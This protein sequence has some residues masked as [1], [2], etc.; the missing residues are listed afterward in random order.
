MSS[1]A[2]RVRDLVKEYEVYAKP[3]DLALEVL[4]RRRRHQIFRALD[5]VSFDVAQGEV[6]G[7]IGSN[8]AGKS[9]LLKLI[10]GVLEPTAGTVDIDGRVT[11]ILELGLGFNPEYSGREN[12]YLSGLLYGMNRE[13]I[14]RK[15]EDIIDFSGLAEFI[16]RPVKTYSSGMHS[17]LAFSIATAVDPDILII[18]EALAAGDSA[19][20]Q[21]CMRRIRQLCSHGRTVLL[22]SHGTGLLAQLCQRVVWVEHGRIKMIGPAINV[23]QAYDLAAHQRADSAGWLDKVDDDLTTAASS[24]GKEQSDPINP[25]AVEPSTIKE[26]IAGSTDG[27]QQVFRRG[28]VFIEGVEMFDASGEVSSRLTL[29]KPFSI[30]IRYRTEGEEPEATLGVALAVNGRYDLAPVA[31]F[32]TQNIRPTETRETYAEANDRATGEGRGSIVLSFAAAPFRKGEYFL[33]IGLLPNIPGSWEFYEYRHLYYTFSVDDCGMDLGAPVFLDAALTYAPTADSGDSSSAQQAADAQAGIDDVSVNSGF[34]TLRDEIEAVCFGDGG[35]PDAWPRHRCCPACAR[36]TVTPL[37]EKYGFNHSR[38]GE[39]GFVC[40]DP[41]PPD[42]ILAKLYSGAYYS[43]TRKLFELP[44]LKQGGKMTPFSAPADLLQRVVEEITG[45]AE[46]GSWLD[47][48]GGLGAFAGLIRKIRPGWAVEL[49]E[50]NQE[51]AAI[52]ESLFDFRVVSDDPAALRAENRTFDVV[53]SVAVL[54]HIPE[55]YDFL[56]SYAELV[57][58][59]GWLIT[60]VPHF[61]PLNAQIS[62]GSSANVVPPY[63]VSLFG[64]EALHRM[65]S[66]LPRMRLSRIEQAGPPAFNLSQHPDTGDHWDITV[67]TEADP[68]PRSIL[69]L[70]Y[71]EEK[72]TLLNSLQKADPL[73]SEF[74]AEHDGRLYL[75][76]F[77]QRI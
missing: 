54:E 27:G 6:L 58:P 75:I 8:G 67:P 29:L 26:I 69:V 77:C 21:K 50:L 2:I 28:P 47:V 35:Y 70:P 17:R 48:G 37:F 31:Q 72:T 53:S 42:A 56:A 24:G 19:F 34:K 23:V 40:V 5:G 74:F 45:D 41:F 66:R 65:M 57:K 62:Q 30:R 15:L 7:I 20:V 25:D 73:L 76:A 4:T 61:T 38:C 12:I 33:S 39:C 51:S 14:D 49:N 59:G 32:F 36:G 55:P 9:T 43:G 68:T 3:V 46:T 63:H 71:D 10:T 18:D 52:A 64:K 44:L 16:E 1:V 13:E 11:A 22:V 60:V